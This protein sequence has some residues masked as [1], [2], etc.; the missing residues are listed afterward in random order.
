MPLCASACAYYEFEN[1][2]MHD[3]IEYFVIYFSI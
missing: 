1:V 3:V 2:G